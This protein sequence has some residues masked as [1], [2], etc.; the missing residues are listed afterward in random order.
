MARMFPRRTRT[1]GTLNTGVGTGSG[2]VR[3]MPEETRVRAGEWIKAPSVPLWAGV[4]VA[5]AG[6]L[7]AAAIMTSVRAHVADTSLAL[8]MV[9]VVVA[10]VS[11]GYRGSS[12]LAG[13]S[14][15]VWFDFFLTRPYESFTI[16]RSA[17]LGTTLLLVA[18]AVA[19]GEIA[20]RSR[21]HRS[22]TT[23]ALGDVA[24]ISRVAAMLAEE[25]PADQ[26]IAAISE[27]L[28]T[29]LSLERCSFEPDGQRRA[30]SVERSGVVTYNV[31]ARDT[32][33]DGLPNADVT[34]PV[35]AGG[36]IAGCFVLRGPAL[37]VPTP[38]A[39]FV[40]AVAL[41]D[42]AA[43]ALSPARST[44]PRLA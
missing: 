41:A 30:P 23:A 36:R 42:L 37:G 8:I 31:F 3:L 22:R 7:V 26:V 24:G 27:E 44:A 33:H 6:P 28:V 2:K 35:E 32:E 11:P 34:L 14:A 16:S 25:R 17:D 20:T 38:A 9:A 18:V 29:L 10:A 21:Q 15:G 4:A 5:V 39:R 43:L 40:T 12:I 19:V 13:L 1:G